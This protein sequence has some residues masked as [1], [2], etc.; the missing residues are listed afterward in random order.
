M[1][2]MV[3]LMSVERDVGGFF[4]T[5]GVLDMAGEA[6]CQHPGLCGELTVES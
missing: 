1:R 3:A 4:L 6:A 2:V 5:C